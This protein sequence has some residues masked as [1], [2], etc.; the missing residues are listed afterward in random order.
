[1]G[2]WGD[3]TRID[4]LQVDDVAAFWVTGPVTI[5]DIITSSD[6]AIAWHHNEA[7]RLAEQGEGMDWARQVWRR[8]RRFR[9]LLPDTDTTIHDIAIS[10]H[11]TDQRHLLKS[12][13]KLQK[14]LDTLG[15]EGRDQAVIRYVSTNT[16][17]AA[18]AVGATP[19]R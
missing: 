16:G 7:S 6:E 17:Q 5:N 10:G 19:N 3:M 18:A 9:D 12:L 11:H 8:D 1:M 14:R 2:L 15:V 13:P 4:D